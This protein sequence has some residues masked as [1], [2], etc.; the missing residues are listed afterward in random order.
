MCARAHARSRNVSPRERATRVAGI[1]SS[2]R[3]TASAP[4]APATP[5]RC[6]KPASRGWAP[7]SAGTPASRD[8]GAMAHSSARHH[9]PCMIAR[10]IVPLA[11][12]LVVSATASRAQTA[13]IY[14]AGLQ[15]WTGCWARE[16]TLT[17]AGVTRFACV[18]PTA[19][20]DVV[21]VTAIEGRI[22]A[23]ESLDATGR[24]AALEAGGCTGT[25]R[26]TWSRDSRRL[27]IRTT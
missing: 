21:Q 18:V 3:S 26:A 20:V 6:V 10:R 17:P 24:L 25:R 1:S 23:Q 8:E 12:L 13:A 11:T 14:G 19:N 16:E 9:V 2:T 7:A 27:F 15:A 4:Q 5:T 22:V